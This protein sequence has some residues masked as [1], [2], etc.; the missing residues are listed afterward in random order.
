MPSLF[1]LARPNWINPPTEKLNRTIYRYKPATSRPYITSPHAS[2]RTVAFPYRMTLDAPE[3]V[4]TLVAW[5]RDSV[6][7]RAKSV[8]VPSYHRDLIPAMDH[9]S[10]FTTLT[11]DKSNYTEMHLPFESRRHLAFMTPTSPI[12]H[13]RV[14]SAVDNL[15]GTETLTLNEAVDYDI[16]KR[17]GMVSFL[18]LMRLESDQL[19]LTYTSA[20]LAQTELVFTEIPNEVPN[21]MININEEWAYY[22]YCASTSSLQ[23]STFYESGQVEF[24]RTRFECGI[25]SS[26]GYSYY[27][28][29]YDG[30]EPGATYRFDVS[31][32]VM[33]DTG[34]LQKGMRLR[35]TGHS[36]V[37]VASQPTLFGDQIAS[38]TGEI[39]VA[40]GMFVLEYLSGPYDLSFG[41]LG[42]TKL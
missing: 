17:H 24:M 4:E 13:R 28:A 31:P 3:E 38:V 23:P 2:A 1:P 22:Q 14:E 20:M 32:A 40:L 41:E 8:W 11:I 25:G 7:G 37:H 39:Q 35:S 27:A 16:T 36:D 12:V 9:A 5:Y 10:G 30:F 21:T 29:T 18:R 6:K 15:D 33:D 34:P 19:K 42:I 26:G